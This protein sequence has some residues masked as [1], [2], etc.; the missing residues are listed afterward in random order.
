MSQFNP[1]VLQLGKFYPIAG[2]VEK[3]MYDLTTGLA[4]KGVSCD[5]LCAAVDG[6][7]F[8]KS[9]SPHSRLIC[10][11]TLFKFAATMIS[12]AMITKLRKICN[13]YDIIHVHHPDPMAS[14]ALRLSGFSGTVVLHWHSDIIRQK[15]FLKLYMPLQTWLLKRADVIVGTTPVYLSESPYL[16]M[17]QHKTA[18]LPIGV[19]AMQPD[20]STTE[21]IRAQYGN[22]KI[23]FSLGRLVHY[24]GFCHLIDAASYLDDDY[25]VLIGG[26]GPLKAD[27]ENQIARLGLENKVKL[28]G[29]ID[30]SE[31]PSYYDACRVFCLSSVQ[32]TEAFAIVQIEAMSCGKPIVATKIKQSGVSWVNSHRES[33]LNV[34]TQAPEELADA[35][36]EI[37][38]DDDVYSAY[39]RRA[40]DRYTTLF[41]KETM[42]DNCIKIYKNTWKK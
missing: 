24:K 27:L 5:M 12:P 41:T 25:V 23:I 38:K 6:D 40:K 26:T 29:R 22:R 15:R 18:S 19:D 16:K 39:S 8:E 17:V 30:D 31:L 32:K 28:L 11:P 34:S 9:L 42:V 35:I 36:K 37:T 33:G 20:K 21:K 3:V 4:E 10:T 7:G 2:G 13:Q 14:L 1:R